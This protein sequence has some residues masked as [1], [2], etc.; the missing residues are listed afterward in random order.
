MP[1]T[2]NVTTGKPKVAGAVYRAPSGTALPTDASTALAAAYLDMG[3]I[4]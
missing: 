2:A 3:Y 4:S 1:N